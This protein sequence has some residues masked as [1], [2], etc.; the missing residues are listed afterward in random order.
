ML[1]T[2]VM[3]DEVA[4]PGYPLWAFRLATGRDSGCR[5]QPSK[6]DAVKNSV[7]REALG[8]IAVDKRC[9]APR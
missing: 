8:F 6:T 5:V 1:G 9:S 4:R 2:E 7:S 3:H